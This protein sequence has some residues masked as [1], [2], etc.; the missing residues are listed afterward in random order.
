MWGQSWENLADIVSPY[1]E[2]STF[3]VSSE[4]QRQGYTVTRMFETAEEF[5]T[6]LGLDPMTNT[7]WKKS[8][9]EQP[10]DDRKVDCHGSAEDF[11]K[12]NDFRF[13]NPFEF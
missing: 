11:Y 12:K 8:M 2:I 5:F 6:S 1:P 4:L 7:F 9:I 13:V 10:T 3:D